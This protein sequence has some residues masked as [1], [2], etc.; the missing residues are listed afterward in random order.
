MSSD[1]KIEQLSEAEAMAELERL[2]N[3]I[4]KHDEAYHGQDAPLI[5]DSD[6]DIL[7][8]PS[9]KT[10]RRVFQNSNAPIAPASALAQ[11]QILALAK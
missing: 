1:K 2:A 6:Y 10:L 5:S 11:P 9:V 4:A 7:R 3:E 8:R